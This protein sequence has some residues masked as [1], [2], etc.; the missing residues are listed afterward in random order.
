MAQIQAGQR[1][2]VTTASG[3]ELPMTALSGVMAGKMFPIIWVTDGKEPR[4]PWPAEYV[5]PA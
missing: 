1:V 3:R 2:V 4:I 5:R